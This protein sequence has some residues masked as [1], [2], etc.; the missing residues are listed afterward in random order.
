[1]V[2]EAVAKGDEES[3][4]AEETVRARA[5]AARAPAG[6]SDEPG[7]P[8]APG[9]VEPSVKKVMTIF[10]GKLKKIQPKP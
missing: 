6:P 10:P 9:D 1:M 4:A 5:L 3:P 7:Q 8:V 2:E